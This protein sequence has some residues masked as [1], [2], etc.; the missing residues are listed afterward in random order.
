M[1][2]I[3]VPYLLFGGLWILL[4]DRLLERIEPDPARRVEWSIWK[5]WAYVLV[6]GVLLALLL[7]RVLRAR[8][9]DTAALYETDRRF[10]LVFRKS[11]IAIAI[12]RLRDGRFIDVNDSFVRLTGYSREEA[13]GRTSVEL[14]LWADP[15]ERGEVLR[16]VR[17]DGQVRAMEI[18]IRRRSGE[19]VPMLYAVERIDIGGEPCLIG[20]AQDIAARKELE[21]ELRSRLQRFLRASPAVLYVLRIEGERV[22]Q[23]WI[24]ENLERITGWTMAESG[25]PA[26]WYA[27]VHP[28]DKERVLEGRARAAEWFGRSK[29]LEY[30]F[31]HKGGAWIWI[32]DEQRYQPAEEGD[33]I[34]AVGTWIDISE[35]K[36][37]EANVV[38]MQKIETVGML[39]GGIAHDFNNLLSVIRGYTELALEEAPP[40]EAGRANLEEIVRATRQAAS[41]TSQLLA[42]SRKQILQPEI[43]NINDVLRETSR[44]L[45]RLIGENIELRLLPR[46]D[47]PPVSADRGQLQQIIMNLAVNA[48]DAMPEGG[49]LLIETGEALFDEEYVRG[50]FPAT[51]GG[52]VM[53]AV[54]DSGAG[55]DAA[56][57]ARIFEPFFTTK[58]KGKGT[59]LGLST[60]YGIVKQSNGFIW[61]YSE[62]GGGTTFKVYL[63]RVEGAAEAVEPEVRTGSGLAGSETILVVEDEAPLRDLACRT[64][65]R[66]GYFVIPASDGDEALERAA[67]RAGRIDMLVT[68]VVMPRMGGKELASRMK[69]RFPGI[70]ILYVSGYTDHS[71]VHRGILDEG[72][73][74]LQKPFSMEG[75][76]RKVRAILDGN[77]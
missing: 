52:Y 51:P 14:D 34:E 56:T 3:I 69:E 58:E 76:V 68:D 72:V 75:L 29:L 40:G 74:F 64:L 49:K 20:M 31:R 24:S 1:A 12:L 15:V 37:L 32:R 53:L 28:E 16:R 11:P 5:G 77:A 67:A 22:R 27:N 17:E 61:V 19:T 50:H 43:L 30:R 26:W 55:M 8:E 54:S 46:A 57:Q 71:I 6:T 25:D 13:L 36:R 47:L 60:V 35:Q 70:R 38:Q 45:E 9:R 59:G 66:K 33:W 7:Y 2:H 44:I 48:R 73:A 10:S 4:S 42:F 65:E 18:R 21:E 63:P 39:A 41:L 62:T 23:E